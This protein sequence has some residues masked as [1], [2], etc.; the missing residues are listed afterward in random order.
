M[1]LLHLADLHI[2]KSVGNF[3]L[4]EDQKYLIDQILKIV[5]REA[6]EAVIVAGD[7]FDTSVP[8][9]EALDLY[10]DFIEE[11]IFKRKIPVLAIAGNHDSSKRLDINKNFYKTNNYYLVGEYTREKIVLYD[12]Y[13]PVNFYLIP[14]ISLAK[15]RLIFD[16]KVEDFTD[17][18]RAALEGISYEG[19]NVLITHCYASTRTEEDDEKY[20][21]GQKPLIIG[22]TDAMDARLF[23]D[24]DY[25]ALGHLHSA[26]YVLDE[27]IRYSGTFMPYSFDKKDTNKSVTIVD[28]KED[29]LDIKKIPIRPLRD[30]EIRTGFFEDL[31][32]DEPSDSYIKFILK[33]K[34]IIENAMARL[35]EKFPRALMLAYEN[36][37]VFK[38]DTYDYD[39]ENK[40]ALELFEDFVDFKD[41]R[42]L[43]DDEKK[44]LKDVIGDLYEG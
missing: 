41:G 29:N 2:G 8:S 12:D 15:G 24:F 33:D 37:S 17:L 11:L 13:G 26:H 35:R 9:A 23:E 7:I 36:R 16:E 4:L 30:F 18:Y 27:K 5:D 14:F 21:E 3:T 44:I 40:D 42:E 31:I 28:L 20:T 38:A 39:I 22:G 34:T 1:R 6:I 43:E 10:N 19:R 25:V 32:K